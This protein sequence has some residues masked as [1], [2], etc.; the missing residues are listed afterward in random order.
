MAGQRT[1]WRQTTTWAMR[2]QARMGFQSVRHVPACSRCPLGDESIGGAQAAPDRLPVKSKHRTD[3][4]RQAV[5]VTVPKVD[6]DDWVCGIGVE[7]RQLLEA[8]A[9]DDVIDSFIDTRRSGDTARADRW[10]CTTPRRPSHRQM[11][12]GLPQD[13]AIALERLRIATL[14]PVVNHLDAASLRTYVEIVLSI[15]DQVVRSEQNPLCWSSAS[16]I[17]RMA[18]A[19]M[20][21]A[22]EHIQTDRPR[23][24]RRG[25]VH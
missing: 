1:R 8:G 17:E 11:A 18:T 19:L 25:P 4:P 5:Q 16:F 15:T 20:D 7:L 22:L 12:Q 3:Y 23:A 2:L 13:L 6:D 24:T 21:V 10:P 9:A 14:T